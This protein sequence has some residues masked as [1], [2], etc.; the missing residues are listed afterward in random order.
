[1]FAEAARE[2]AVALVEQDYELVYGGGSTGIMAVLAD[3]VLAQ[4]GKVYGVIPKLLLQK[5][6]GHDGLTEL[7]VVGSMHERK[8]KMAS[9]SD[10]FIALPGGFG[11]LEE[12]SE[13]LTWGQLRLHEKP[14][15]VVNIDGYFDSLLAYLDNAEAEGFLRKE[16]RQML[17][18]AEDPAALLEQFKSYQAPTV[19]KWI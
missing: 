3:A 13:I 17:C 15:G 4:G 1:M 18:C 7:H 2:L 9:M 8:S 14:V 19:D 16:C 5:E 10:A 12:I 11:T 6:V